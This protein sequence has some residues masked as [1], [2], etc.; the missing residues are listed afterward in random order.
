MIQVLANV[1]DISHFTIQRS[2][3]VVFTNLNTD[4]VIAKNADKPI[5][6]KDD[7]RIFTKR[8][9]EIIRLIAGSHSSEEIADLLF[10]SK[11]TDRTH[12]QNILKNQ[13]KNHILNLSVL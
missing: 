7:Y 5:N 10:I 11:N 4:E 3:N 13:M 6:K 12:R 1:S 2:S 9:K 8:E